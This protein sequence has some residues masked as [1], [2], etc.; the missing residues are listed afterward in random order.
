[1]CI[2]ATIFRSVKSRSYGM[3][4]LWLTMA[5]L[6]LLWNLHGNDCVDAL[7]R[8]GFNKFRTSSWSTVSI[9]ISFASSSS[10]AAA[11]AASSSPSLFMSGGRKDNAMSHI[12]GN[13]NN[14]FFK[15]NFDVAP[16]DIGGGSNRNEEGKISST[17][18]SAVSS[19]LDSSST[20]Q[21]SSSGKRKKKEND[22]TVNSLENSNMKLGI[23]LLNLGGP[24]KQQD[25]EG[26]LYNLFADPDIIR[27]PPGLS[28]F[29]K[30]LAMFIAKRRAPKSKEAYQSIGGGSPIVAYTSEQASLI[31]TELAE[32]G[33]PSKAYFAMRYWHPFTEDVLGMFLTLLKI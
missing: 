21:G 30:P 17:K 14:N 22:N 31:E 29:Q 11:S 5:M 33:L 23:L 26:F 27:L 10:A 19:T 24:E 9:P 28:L 18:L 13:T 15:F 8:T 3:K 16:S 20:I 1:M 12:N 6:L 32:R 25:V 7:V 2:F 4:L